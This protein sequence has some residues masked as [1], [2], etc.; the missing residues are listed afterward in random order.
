MR[1]PQTTPSRTDA[2]V[3]FAAPEFIWDTTGGTEI[4]KDLLRPVLDLLRSA[5]AGSLLDLGCGNGA[6][7]ERL[8]SAGFDVA[9]C[10]MS[11]SGIA[12]A[13][14]QLPGIPFFEHAFSEPL[15]SEHVGRYDAVVSTEVIEH[16][17]L[18]RLLLKCAWAALRPGGILVLSTPFHGYWKNLALALLNRFDSH[19]H[20]LRDYGHVKFFSKK[21]LCCLLREQGF[22]VLSCSLVGRVRL[23]PRC[24]V[25]GAIKST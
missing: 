9:G 3:S 18:P 12:L 14:H 21:T 15:P 25:V 8:R 17:L 7:T 4:H 2:N 1:K 20:P 19:W 11:S 5:S 10:D 24:M 6:F 22:T 13:R 16:L 23:L